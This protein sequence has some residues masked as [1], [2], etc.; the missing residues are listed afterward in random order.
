MRTVIDVE[1][2]T[3]ANVKHFATVKKFSLNS[4]VEILLQ[5]ALTN[6]GYRQGDTKKVD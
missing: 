6:L 2:K 3:W 4:A 5:Q 1:R